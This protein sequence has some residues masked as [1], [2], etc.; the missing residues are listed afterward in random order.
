[1]LKANGKPDI[2]VRHA[3]SVLP[4]VAK[5]RI[6]RCRRVDGK[7]PGIPDISGAVEELKRIYQAPAGFLARGKLE[8]GE[9]A[10]AALKIFPG[11][12]AEDIAI[13]YSARGL[14]DIG[15][16]FYIKSATAIE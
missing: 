12:L 6:C 1:M 9:P 15:I 11:A 8:A 4:G 10:E 5:L 3:G 7:A 2:A 14:S 16:I 13:A